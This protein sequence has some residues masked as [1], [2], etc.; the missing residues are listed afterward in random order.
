MKRYWN[1]LF[2]L[3]VLALQTGCSSTTPD[4]APTD[5]PPVDAPVADAGT[6]VVPPENL[7]Q[8]PMPDAAALEQPPAMDP[9]PAADPN[10]APPAEALPPVADAAPPAEMPAPDT[11]ST[12]PAEAT[13]GE[14]MTYAV[15]RGDTL[16]KIAYE[17]YGDFKQWRKILNQNQDKI[18][19]PNRIAQ[20]TQLTVEKPAQA[21]QLSQNGERYEIKAGDTL[22]T[23]SKEVYGT[24]KKWRKIYE[25]N[26]QLIQDPNKIYAGFQLYYTFGPEDE[27]EK[28]QM[29]ASPLAA[30]AAG[31]A[32]MPASGGPAAAAP[33]MPMAGPATSP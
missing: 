24:A 23:I 8:P 27:Q 33:A 16:M 6:D 17:V 18:Q 15:K 9:P 1:Y 32:R 22:G 13:T 3:A 31:D 30:T 25:N 29:E 5:A 19:D 20:G 21:V 10:A 7:E 28:K 14:T 11:L 26:K 12:A 4:E 2:V